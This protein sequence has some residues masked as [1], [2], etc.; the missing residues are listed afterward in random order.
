MGQDPA[1][2]AE[3]ATAWRRPG[4]FATGFATSLH[5][6]TQVVS[7]R[8]V[9]KLD[10]GEICDPKNRSRTTSCLL[11]EEMSP[12]FS[13]SLRTALARG[14]GWGEGRQLARTCR[15]PSRFL[16]VAAPHPVPLPIRVQGMG[17]GNECAG[18]APLA[19]CLLPHPWRGG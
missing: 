2:A 15:R 19:S 14:E 13:L 3:A 17:R 8:S 10:F 11:P 6:G 12:R 16:R 9:P 4:L 1:C 18:T 7:V 5:P